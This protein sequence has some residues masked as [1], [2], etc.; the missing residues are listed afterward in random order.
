MQNIKLK[1]TKKGLVM[2]KEKGESI[3]KTGD[4]G[5]YKGLLEQ[6][7]GIIKEE[8]DSQKSEFEAQLK[9]LTDQYAGLNQRLDTMETQYHQLSRTLSER[10]DTVEN[11]YQVLNSKL[12]NYQSQVSELRER[13]YDLRHDMRMRRYSERPISKRERRTFNRLFRAGMH[14]R[15]NSATDPDYELFTLDD[16]PDV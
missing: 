14:C 9:N 5:E 6:I 3:T 11:Q 2:G 13:F 16:L 10:L 1:G 4:T 12:D 7:R 8:F 15:G